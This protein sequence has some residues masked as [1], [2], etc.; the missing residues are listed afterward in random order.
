MVERIYLNPNEPDPTF[1]VYKEE[2]RRVMLK[3]LAGKSECFWILGKTG[4]GKTTFLLWINK[5]AP[6]Y[7]LK[8]IYFHGGEEL[9]FED[10]KNGIEK[11]IKASFF[12]RIFLKKRYTESPVLILIDEAEHVNDDRI[13]KYVVSKLDEPDLNFSVVLSSV[14][15]KEEIKQ[16][17][18]GREIDKIYLEKPSV[19]ILMEMIRKRIEAGGGE[20][21]QPFGKQLIKDIIEASDTIREILI[22]LEEVAK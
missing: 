21:Y 9:K 6:L 13:W 16:Y 18:K 20:G 11:L 1:M 4:I 12:S 15:E 3:A 5:F 8:S 17:F 14:E 10:F 7:K 2:A 22:K 19:D